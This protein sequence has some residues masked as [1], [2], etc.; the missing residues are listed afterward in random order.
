MFHTGKNARRS[1][2]EEQMLFSRGIVNKII[3]NKPVEGKGELWD[4][5]EFDLI[6]F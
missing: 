4:D 1:A 5:F 3:Q 2:A 6:A